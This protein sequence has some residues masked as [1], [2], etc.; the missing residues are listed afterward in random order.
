VSVY[1]I[2]F[3]GDSIT[4]ASGFPLQPT[5]GGASV[6]VDAKA[7]PMLS[8][9]PWQINFELPQETPVKNANFQVSFNDGIVT[10]AEVIAVEATGP[11]VFVTEAQQAAVLHAGT[12]ILV[13]DAHPGKAGETLELF[14]TGLGV[15]DPLVA[16][17]QPSPANPPAVAR[18]TPVVL[19]NNNV[20]SQ[21]LF[22][23]LAPGLAGVYQ[24]N[25]VVPTGL[26]PGHTTITLSNRERTT[27][28]SGTIT[29][30]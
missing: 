11:A 16:A 30:Q 7:V 29:V 14:G 21:V 3:S 13:D 2:N 25:F 10:A 18:I 4:G 1:G 28:S 23:G 15:T 24:V 20:P 22:A 6:L 19:I 9:S 17:G 26:K 27:G 8:V 12:S 5:L